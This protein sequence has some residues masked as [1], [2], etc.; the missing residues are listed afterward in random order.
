MKKQVMRL[1]RHKRIRAKIAGTAT[2]P[3]LAVFR[4]NRFISAQLIDDA[5]RRTVASA[6]SRSLKKLSS[7]DLG[8]RTPGV[9]RAYLTGKLM[10]ERAREYGIKSICFDR[11]GFSYHG[12]VQAL[13]DGMRATGIKF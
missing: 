10:G 7:K 2:I 8:G 5:Q 13:A 1:R 4:S 12:Q 6:T 9:A 11:G 3:R